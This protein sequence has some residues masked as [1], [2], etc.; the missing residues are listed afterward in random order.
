[1]GRSRSGRDKAN[2]HE[3]PDYR[4]RSEVGGTGFSVGGGGE[5]DVEFVRH[6]EDINEVAGVEQKWENSW[7]TSARTE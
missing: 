5:T 2:R 7:I 3:V 6:L 4:A 1:M